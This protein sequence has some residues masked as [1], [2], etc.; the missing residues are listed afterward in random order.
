MCISLLDSTVFQTAQLAALASV[1]ELIRHDE[2]LRVKPEVSLGER[3]CKLETS[4]D[5]SFS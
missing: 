3:S 2:I 4:G 5:K 1:K